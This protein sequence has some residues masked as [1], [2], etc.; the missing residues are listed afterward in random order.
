MATLEGGTA[1]TALLGPK[2]GLPKRKPELQLLCR[3][4]GL[5][6]TGTVDDLRV[7]LKTQLSQADRQLLRAGGVTT[8]PVAPKA[9]GP[10]SATATVEAH[11]IHSMLVLRR[12]WRRL[13][14]R[15]T[16]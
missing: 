3:T 6:E 9:A 2:G 1:Y 4:L 12:A 5:S 7:R 13:Q 14:Q 8:V 10:P 15:P 16:L 11:T